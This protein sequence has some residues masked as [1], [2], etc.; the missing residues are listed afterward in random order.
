[1]G[2]HVGVSPSQLPVLTRLV[3]STLQSNYIEIEWY[4]RRRLAEG[5]DGEEKRCILSLSCSHTHAHAKKRLK[6]LAC[7]SRETASCCFL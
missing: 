3:I 6:K 1:M 2:I 4:T 7:A 5:V